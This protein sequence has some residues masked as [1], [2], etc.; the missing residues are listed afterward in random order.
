MNRRVVLGLALCTALL[1]GGAW[2][3]FERTV[4][5]PA[6]APAAVIPAVTPAP[7]RLESESE[8]IVEAVEGPVQRSEDGG[9]SALAVG[10][11]LRAD[12]SL[13]TGNGARADLRIGEKSR[14][15]VSQASQLTIRELSE[16]V[17]RFKLTRG[18]VRVDYAPDG[19]RVL[20]IEGE[21]NGAV[22]ETR[23][24]KFSVLSTG[25]A[26]A[27]A[28]DAGSVE[29]KAQGARVTV[30]AGEQAVARSGEKPD[31]PKPIPPALWLKVANA[32]PVV[33]DGVCAEVTGSA[34]AGSEVT[35][36]GR[37]VDL[38][39]DGSFSAQVPGEP[40]KSEVLVAIR[41][42]AGRTANRKVP[43]GGPTGG[44]QDVALRWRSKAQ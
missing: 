8:A 41:D 42:P 24:A 26:I 3:V 28:A 31:A 34:P 4:H 19:E 13:R 1:M 6:P 38:A 9:W 17:H 39:A 7:A 36:D 32:L 10:D 11:R 2:L 16:K 27:I 25:R 23:S 12:D 33:P 29:L 20:R 5:R 18:Y 40:G 15:A 14:I 44:V 30:A 35:A 37:D 22:A 43:C 21:G